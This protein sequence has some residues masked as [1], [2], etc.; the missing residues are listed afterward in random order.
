MAT[1]E[2]TERKQSFGVSVNPQRGKAL[3]TLDKIGAFASGAGVQSGIDALEPLNQKYGDT[4]VIGSGVTTP[5][6]DANSPLI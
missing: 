4:N 3:T 6:P 1:I 2:T 5:V